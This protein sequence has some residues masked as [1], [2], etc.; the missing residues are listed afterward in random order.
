MI[1]IVDYGRGNLFSIGQAL[2][3]LGVD[4]QISSKPEDL[5]NAKRIIFPG[6]GAFGDAMTGLQERGLVEPLRAAAQGG[7]PFL[8]I[9]VGCQLLLSRGE[10]FGAN[11]GLNLIPGVVSRLPVPRA[12]DPDA[13]RIPNVGW[14]PLSVQYNAPIVGQIATEDWMYFVHS[15]APMVDDPANISA[16]IAVNGQDIPVAIC[17]DNIFGV[18][19]HPEKSGPAGL[20]VLAHFLEAKMEFI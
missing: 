19:F 18:Q 13:I 5:T 6:V 7:I 11:D 3:Q 9:C 1:V 14:R 16:T 15:Y 20:R 12:E 10:E 8:G 2:W 17:R 4:Y